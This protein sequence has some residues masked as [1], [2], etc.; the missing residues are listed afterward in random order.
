[1][2]SY[3]MVYVIGL[4]MQQ[5]H[6]QTFKINGYLM[7]A[8]TFLYLF[9]CLMLYSGYSGALKSLLTV[10]VYPSPP[11]T[12]A[13]LAKVATEQNWVI[14]TCCEPMVYQMAESSDP[15]KRAIAEKLWL[16]TYEV[17]G[18]REQSFLN[19]SDFKT[20]HLRKGQQYA[21]VNTIK[22]LQDVQFNMLSD[23]AGN[24]DV[25]IMDDCFYEIAIAF[26]LGKNSPYKESLDRKITQL[27]EGGFI[28]KWM[29]AGEV[30]KEIHSHARKD[31]PFSMEQLQGL[32][33]LYLLLIT[34]SFTVF[35]FE[36]LFR[37]CTKLG[38]RHRDTERRKMN[39]TKSQGRKGKTT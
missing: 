30:K 2:L 14:T 9:S 23:E 8:I 15:N 33:Y 35:V 36:Y 26:G 12:F 16:N 28:H 24:T 19:V 34:L 11:N 1:M 13:E 37:F 39:D 31:T 22:T 27:R 10:T 5:Y 17:D 4:T 18:W 25:H 6:E 7:R 29:K 38:E 3:Y 20:G 21:T 32:F